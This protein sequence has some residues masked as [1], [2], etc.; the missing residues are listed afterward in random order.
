MADTVPHCEVVADHTD[1]L[2]VEAG[3][4]EGPAR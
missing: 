3:R 1:P 4:E 2:T